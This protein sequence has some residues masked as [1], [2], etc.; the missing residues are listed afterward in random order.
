MAL[1]STPLQ[2]TTSNH[3][4]SKSL[5]VGVSSAGAVVLAA[6]IAFIIWRRRRNNRP[7]KIPVA[8]SVSN[9]HSPIIEGGET[10]DNYIPRSQSTPS[11]PP[12][13]VGETTLAGL[14]TD[15]SLFLNP[16]IV[17]STPIFPPE[18]QSKDY[19]G[20]FNIPIRQT[21]TLASLE[22]RPFMARRGPDSPLN[23]NSGF[24]MTSAIS[25]PINAKP[26]S[27]QLYDTT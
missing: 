11:P 13:T 12:Y 2:S 19:P 17:P 6:I 25:A 15:N 22:K 3:K 26:S 24:Y 14:P 4:V 21:T 5:V 10:R 16:T 1:T 20:H 27:N 8:A 18:I 23:A 9:D 7:R